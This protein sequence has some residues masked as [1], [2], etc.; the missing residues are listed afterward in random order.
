MPADLRGRLDPKHG[1]ACFV[2]VE[3]NG[4]VLRLVK[5]VN[6]LDPLVAM[7]EYEYRAGRT[8]NHRAFAAE[9]GI[10]LDYESGRG[11]VD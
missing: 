8:K 5:A 9:D 7:A 11:R 1:D 6:P 3:D 10:D 4:F 2:E